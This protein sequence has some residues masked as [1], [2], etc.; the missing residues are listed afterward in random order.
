MFVGLPPLSAGFANA[1]DYICHDPR[2]EGR[3]SLP[4]AERVAYIGV[5]S[6]PR[7]PLGDVAK[8]METTVADAEDLKALAGVPPQGTKI[9]KPAFRFVLSW[10]PDEDPSLDEVRE[11][12]SEYL[13]AVRLAVHQ[14]VFSVHVDTDCVHVHGVANRVHPQTGRAADVWYAGLKSQV[15]ARSWEERHGGIRCPRRLTAEEAQAWSDLRRDQRRDQ[16][17][18]EVARR[19]QEALAAWIDK[20]RT[21][22]GEP[23]AARP[24]RSDPFR[25]PRRESSEEERAQ[26]DEQFERHRREGTSAEVRRRERLELARRIDRQRRDRQQAIR[27]RGAA[28]D[29]DLDIF[30]AAKEAPRGAGRPGSQARWAFVEKVIVP[31]AEAHLR[32]TVRARPRDRVPVQ[33]I[34]EMLSEE[35][36]FRNHHTQP[37][38]LGRYRWCDDWEDRQV[39]DTRY[40]D[41]PIRRPEQ[42]ARCQQIRERAIEAG[43]PDIDAYAQAQV[44]PWQR[45]W[46]LSGGF[47][48]KPIRH[49]GYEHTELRWTYIE[50]HAIPRW[51]AVRSHWQAALRPRPRVLERR[52]A[53]E[54][55]GTRA[56]EPE[57]IVPRRPSVRPGSN[58]GGARPVS[59]GRAQLPAVADTTA[60]PVRDASPARS[61]SIA[62]TNEREAQTQ[63]G[64]FGQILTFFR[65]VRRDRKAKRKP[66]LDPILG[67]P[68]LPERTA[69]HREPVSDTLQEASTEP[70]ESQ[71]RIRVPAEPTAKRP[72]PKPATPPL[73]PVEA[74]GNRDVTPPPPRPAGSS[75]DQFRGTR[76]G[77]S[78]PS[79]GR[80]R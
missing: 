14:V 69:D 54:A 15:W 8:I 39:P 72:S 16:V 73:R 48:S 63:R 25:W 22:R 64:W 6:V 24:G 47:F 50:R 40:L 80:T 55:H 9:S 79:Q 32:E 67:T 51:E 19:E 43:V 65:D 77:P 37:H 20:R 17:G 38:S 30:V 71:R 61:E 60:R 7:C 23:P 27:E 70:V 33:V 29:I 26:W 53:A 35:C 36:S 44:L 34:D 52:P 13:L 42:L 49:G 31:V 46:Q 66:R 56:V 59:P 5:R 74:G 62:E 1:I 78:K 28:V 11:A 68:T 2:P 58:V 76:P 57:W 12:V 10:A 18:R 75:T 45:A 3:G 4:T 21:A 41:D